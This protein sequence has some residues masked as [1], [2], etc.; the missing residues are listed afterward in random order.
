[1]NWE[2]RVSVQLLLLGIGAVLA[3]PLAASF[4]GYSLL[5]DLSPV[6]AWMENRLFREVTGYVGLTLALLQIALSVRKR[7]EWNF[8]G[9]SFP[10]WR[11]FHILAGV[12][13]LLVIVVHTGGRWGWN[14][15]GWL[16]SVFVLAVFVGLAG[17]VWESWLLQSALH[18]V[19]PRLRRKYRRVSVGQTQA[20]MPIA[21]QPPAGAAQLRGKVNRARNFWLA[22]HI[23]LTAGF[24]VLLGF[25]VFSV[26]YF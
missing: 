4:V 25:H 1:M 26:Y 18:V 21:A 11:G 16:Q 19:K 12:A 14:L 2:T 10:T 8:P 23:V 3:I 24:A 22:A 9:P 7:V 5:G 6:H 15:N 20:S 17:K 13:F